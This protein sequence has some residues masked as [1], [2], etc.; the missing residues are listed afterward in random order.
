M[1]NHPQTGPWEPLN[2]SSIF[3]N[4][5]KQAARSKDEISKMG[6]TPF[7]ESSRPQPLPMPVLFDS[8]GIDYIG[9]ANTLGGAKNE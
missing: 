3:F 9:S 6:H 2:I 7:Y 4:Q 8:L 5:I 1:N